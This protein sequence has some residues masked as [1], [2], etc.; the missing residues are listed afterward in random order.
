MSDASGGARIKVG[1]EQL[2][3]AAA[4]IFF[5]QGYAATRIDDIIERTGG[6][7]RNIYSEFGNKEGLF[8]A[9]VSQQAGRALSAL[10]IDNLGG[11]SLKDMLTTFGHRLIDIY[12]SPVLLGVYRIAITECARFP[13][14]VRRF[15]DLG[16]GRAGATLAAVLVAAQ[17][18]GEIR[19]GD[20]AMAGDHFVG[21]IR[22]NLHLQVMLGLREPPDTAEREALVASVVDL[23]LDGVEYRGTPRGR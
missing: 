13:D 19:T 14:L 11:Q 23:F 9:I 3:A 16:P 21:M 6:S 17:E 1:R 8:A 5:E 10:A 2:L 22:G 7:K 15:Y 18:R 4:A 12:M 20:C